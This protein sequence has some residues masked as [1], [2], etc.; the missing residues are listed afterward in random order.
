LMEALIAGVVTKGGPAVV[1][2][3]NALNRAHEDLEDYI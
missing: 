2:R 1:K 3:L